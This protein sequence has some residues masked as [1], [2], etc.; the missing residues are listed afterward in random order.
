LLSF[1]QSYGAMSVLERAG[2]RWSLRRLNEEPML[3]SA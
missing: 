3:R 2:E 1:G